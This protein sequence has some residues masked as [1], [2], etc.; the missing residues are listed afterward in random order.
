MALEAM[1][2]LSQNAWV[3]GHLNGAGGNGRCANFRLAEQGAVD[4]A[5]FGDFGETGDLVIVQRAGEADVDGDDV[6]I[7]VGRA[8]A[9]FA[10]F[11]LDAGIVELH[12]DFFQ[13]PLLAPGVHLHRHDFAGGQRTEQ[14]AIG[15]GAS[16]VAAAVDG[17][18]GVEMEFV[19]GEDFD[20]EIVETSGCYGHFVK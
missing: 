14:E 1:S 5:A 3:L 8:G 9:I 20:L 11:G 7:G 6:D 16:V 4:G 17:F 15:I 12:F 13:R 2:T 10:I 19:V 18:I